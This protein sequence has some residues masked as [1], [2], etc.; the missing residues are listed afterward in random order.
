MTVRRRRVDVEA[1]AARHRI[2]S[3]IVQRGS[4][5]ELVS[6]DHAVRRCCMLRSGHAA[7]A[8]RAL[9]QRELTGRQQPTP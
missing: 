2:R 1:L 9:V 6:H 7:G 8:A 5:E 4:H 3:A